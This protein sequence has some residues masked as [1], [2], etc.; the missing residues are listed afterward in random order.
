M[1]K[2]DLGHLIIA[3]TDSL[4]RI[5]KSILRNETDCEDAVS[6]AIVKSFD[7]INTLQHASYAKTW[8]IRIL[9]NE[10]HNIGRR[11]KRVTPVDKIPDQPVWQAE[12]TGMM[13]ALQNLKEP[14]RIVLTMHELE[15][16]TYSEIAAVTHTPESTVKYRAV[17]A[18][19]ALRREM[20][21]QENELRGGATR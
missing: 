2:E 6:E 7:K 16:F 19:R 18:R 4:Y 9:I 15:G 10:C 1:T 11:L 5:S 17:Q 8:L 13:E 20:E 12:E 21:K 3:S 14:W